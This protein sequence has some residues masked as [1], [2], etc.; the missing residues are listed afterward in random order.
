MSG[1]R[2]MAKIYLLF[3]ISILSAI[4]AGC[5][6]NRTAPGAVSVQEATQPCLDCHSTAASVVTD[7]VIYEEWKLSKHNGV[8]GAGCAHCHEPD[9][10]HPNS[11]KS[12]HGVAPPLGSR[13]DV[14]LNPDTS[15]KCF[16]CHTS[17]TLVAPHF[18]N[19]TTL[20]SSLSTYRASYVSARYVGNCRKCHNPH[21]P[22]SQIAANQ[23]WAKSGHGD[24]TSSAWAA[25][26][27]KTRGTAGA[28]PAQTTAESCV[29][30]HTTTGYINYVVSGLTDISG[31]GR[32]SLVNLPAFPGDINYFNSVD[33][34]KQVLACDACHDDGK[35]NA[36]KWSKLRTVGAVTAY[37]NYSSS[38]TG[39]LLVNFPFANANTSNGCIPCHTGRVSGSA[40]KAI[41]A[42]E[43]ASGTFAIFSSA[44]AGMPFIDAHNMSAGA[45]IFK[46]SGY[47]YAGRDYTNPPHYEHD[48]IGLG[49][50]DTGTYGPCIGCHMSSTEKHSFQVVTKVND[51][52]IPLTASKR[53]A[54]LK[55]R[56]CIKCH[57]GPDERTASFMQHE[58]EGYNAALAALAKALKLR[59][60]VFKGTFPYF[61][62]K[63]WQT[64]NGSTGGYGAGTGGRTM[65]AAFNFNLLFHDSGAFAHNNIYAKR[66]IYDS[67]YWITNGPN[68]TLSVDNAIN[69]LP[70]DQALLFARDGTKINFDQTVKAAAIAYLMGTDSNPSGVGNN[71]P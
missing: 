5:G 52:S 54:A 26:D 2:K 23:Q 27:F 11:C 43:T 12:C 46:S 69:S 10:G 67:I 68:G 42:I 29:R 70:D 40:I 48:Q 59:A 22:T 49:S 28:T 8:N 51:P 63:N 9:A 60:F 3:V 4:L 16:K 34:T 55:S 47:E 41:E 35:G 58:N 15:L 65:G 13:H 30:C 36:Y 50:Y 25:Y 44:G 64:S 33:K 37:Y 18:T 32:Q 66:L 39:K 6:D 7:A 57:V 61:S 21:D 19:V 71:R 56:I 62:N 31:W 20:N 14:L 17:K 53:I 45:T 24:T 1:L 38:S